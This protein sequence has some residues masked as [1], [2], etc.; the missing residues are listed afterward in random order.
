[1]ISEQIL[2][3]PKDAWDQLIRWG[4]IYNMSMI[5]LLKE[6]LDICLFAVWWR[7]KREDTALISVNIRQ[8]P[9]SLA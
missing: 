4:I 2:T 6:Y 1:M 9:F 7:E 8:Q 5:V 3:A